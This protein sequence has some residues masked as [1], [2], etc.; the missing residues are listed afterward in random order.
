VGSSDILYPS[1]V[2]R[3]RIAV[4]FKEVPLKIKIGL[5]YKRTITVNLPTT[6]DWWLTREEFEVLSQIRE[7]KT[8]SSALIF[9]LT[10]FIT[11]TLVSPNTVVVTLEMTGEDTRKITA[12]GY[13]DIVM[14]DVGTKDENAFA[15]SKGSVVLSSLIT[16]AKE[17]RNERNSC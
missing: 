8:T 16:G 3:W 4:A 9:D 5:P 6:R 10:R 1:S 15:I 12:A 2:P 7:K 13:Y 14:S 17:D 11:A